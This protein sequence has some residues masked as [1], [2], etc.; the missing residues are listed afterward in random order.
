MTHQ[1][2]VLTE[3]AIKNNSKR[4]QKKI[5]IKSRTNRRNNKQNDLIFKI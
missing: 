5:I 4:L 2:L 1:N 3:N